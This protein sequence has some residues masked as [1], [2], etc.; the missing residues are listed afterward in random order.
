[1]IPASVDASESGAFLTTEEGVAALYETPADIFAP[2]TNAASV[3]ALVDVVEEIVTTTDGTVY[4]SSS[5]F[6]EGRRSAVRTEETNLGNLSADAN[7]AKA[8]EIDSSVVI[9]IKNGGG[10]RAEIGS[11]DGLTGEQGPTLPNPFSGKEAG[12]ISQLDLE[13][14]LRFNNGLTLLS[15][16]ASDLLAVLEHAVSAS[17]E[18]ATPGQFPQVGGISFSFDPLLPA[19]E[20][21]KTVALKNENSET[22][23]LIVN[24][25][26]VIGDPE[27]EFRI[28]TLGFLAGGGDSYPFPELGSNLV[29]TEIGEQQALA[30]FLTT[31]Y[32]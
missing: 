9:S 17:G 16:S 24:E 4:G 27:R 19:G 26:E 29:D 3:K 11:I 21:V 23:D 22:I 2:G 31:N 20:R 13:N 6:L 5:V 25:G 15:L 32:S 30:E 14:T 8:R 7:L 1:V 10:I 12:Q 18:S 28:V